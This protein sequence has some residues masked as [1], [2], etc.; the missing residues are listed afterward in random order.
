VYYNANLGETEVQFL[1][2]TTAIGGGEITNPPF[3]FNPS[4]TVVGVGEFT[5]DGFDDD[6]V[7]YNAST[8]VYELQELNG[9]TATNTQQIPSAAGLATI[10]GQ[11][12]ATNV[13][14]PSGTGQEADLLP[15]TANPLADGV[16]GATAPL[17]SAW[18]LPFSGGAQAS[19]DWTSLAGGNFNPNG[20]L[21][22]AGQSQ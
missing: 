16:G 17:D 15:A 12:S 6:I 3:E 22:S 19:L 7:H 8:G 1:K 2:G 18:A 5:D 14:P 21:A 10:D 4:W 20:T 13:A 11:A 9:T